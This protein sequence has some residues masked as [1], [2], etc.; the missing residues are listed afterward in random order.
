[1]R[2]PADTIEGIYKRLSRYELSRDPGAMFEYSNFGTG[3]LGLALSLR[4]GKSYEALLIERVLQPL[5]MTRTARMRGP[6]W[7]TL[8]LPAGQL[9]LTY[10]PSHASQR[11]S[12]PTGR[13][14]RAS[15]P[16]MNGDE[17]SD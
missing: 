14:T 3:L 16:R 8:W 6:D 10:V 12:L 13:P 5:R 17:R 15:A 7:T 4:A 2:F 9:V 11:C 1:M